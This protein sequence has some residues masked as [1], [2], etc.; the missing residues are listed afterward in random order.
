MLFVADRV[1]YVKAQV[2][3]REL[4]KDCYLEVEVRATLMHTKIII[5]VIPTLDLKEMIPCVRLVALSCVD[6][7]EN[8]VG[9]GSVKISK[10]NNY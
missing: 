10:L 9:V 7:K 1:Y 6:L 4:A 2:L 8:E 3:T 5:R